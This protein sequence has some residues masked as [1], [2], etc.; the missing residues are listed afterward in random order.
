MISLN[1]R[2]GRTAYLVAMLASAACTKQ[3]EVPRAES[4]VA[5]RP[6]FDSAATRLLTAL[7]ADNS[8]SVFALMADDVMLMPPHEPVLKGKAAARTWYGQF[9]T[10]LRTSSLAIS[11]RE[12]TI[13]RD[14]ATEISTY[15]WVLAPLDG[16]QTITEK[17]TYMQLWQREPTG[18]WLMKR[19]IW[20]ST[21]PVAP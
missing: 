20:N 9:L 8:D 5:L 2:A 3:S 17:G 15:E 14:Q 1:P 12:V 16:G 10:Q 4:D 7:Q 21:A 18:E 11:D 13:A 6:A 19:E